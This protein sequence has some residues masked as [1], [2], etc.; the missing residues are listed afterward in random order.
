LYFEALLIKA[1]FAT[2]CFQRKGVLAD[3]KPVFDFSVKK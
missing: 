2:Y 1:A 3:D